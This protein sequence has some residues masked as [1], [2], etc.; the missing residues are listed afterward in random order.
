MVLL[1][2]AKECFREAHQLQGALPGPWAPLGKV[3]ILKNPQGPF[4]L[5][6]ASQSRLMDAEETSWSQLSRLAEIVT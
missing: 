3:R 5:L 1:R 2:A 6:H 4:M